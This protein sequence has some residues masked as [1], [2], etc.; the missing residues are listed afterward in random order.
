MDALNGVKDLQ[1]LWTYT[2]KIHKQQ[3]PESRLEPVMAGGKTIKPKVMF[4]F[5]NPTYKNTS[6]DSN[7]KGERRPWQGTKYIW[8]IFSDAGIFS[9]VLLKEIQ[10]KR[11]WDVEFA[12]K[13][14]KHIE[15]RD[16]YFTN[17]V[18]W[19]GENADLP[20]ADKVKLFLP[21]LLREIELVYPEKIVTFGLIPFN[22]LCNVKL[23]LDDYYH[24]SLANNC[25]R[26]Y[27]VAVRGN[28]F[29]V[30]PCYFPVGRGNP[31]RATKLLSMLVR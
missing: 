14:Y 5:I 27:E 4:V 26:S 21:I 23:R 7:W 2:T 22:A 3:F 28:Y 24:E 6:S 25:L 19:T 9:Q 10:G 1:G 30:V 12:D 17:L 13:V 11:T 15:D 29:K 16:F 8:K 18:K 31:K 20:N